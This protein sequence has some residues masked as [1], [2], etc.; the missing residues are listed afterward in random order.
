[1]WTQN[2][3]NGPGVGVGWG[4]A[5]KPRDVLEVNCTGFM[6]ILLEYV[7]RRVDACQGVHVEVRGQ[8]QVAVTL[9]EG[10]IVCLSGCQA[11]WPPIPL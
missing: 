9:F 2:W 6:S 7:L 8:A 10:L 3:I 11:S 1:M 4:E 5:Q